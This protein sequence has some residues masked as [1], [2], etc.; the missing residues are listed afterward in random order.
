MPNKI[1]KPTNFITVTEQPKILT[2]QQTLNDQKKAAKLKQQFA[3]FGVDS[4]FGSTGVVE[5]PDGTFQ[6]QF[7]ESA[8][9]VQRGQLIGQGLSGLNLDPTRQ[10][11]AFF[12]RATRKLLPQFEESREAL[13]ERLINQGLDPSS[14][15]SERRTRLLEEQQQGTLSDLANQSVFAGQ[16]FTGG[17]ISNIN[18]LGAGRDIFSLASLASPTGATF[19]SN[20]AGAIDSQ[21]AKIESQNKANTEFIARIA[22]ASAGGA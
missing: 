19:G 14:E 21:N 6:R 4:P 16:D 11:D 9:D 7:D 5:Q 8:Q 15:Q 13:Q 18:Q 12:D 3:L 10:E 1:T 2:P 17:Q 20:L 22:R